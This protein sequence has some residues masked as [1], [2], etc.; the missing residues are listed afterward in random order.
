VG[1]PP[2]SR[3]RDPPATAPTTGPACTPGLPGPP[4]PPASPRPQPFPASSFTVFRQCACGPNGGGFEKTDIP[5]A[6]LTPGWSFVGQGH[7]PQQACPCGSPLAGAARLP[8]IIISAFG[9]PAET[10]AV[11][12][13]ADPFSDGGS[14]HGVDFSAPMFETNFQAPPRGSASPENPP[15]HCHRPAVLRATARSL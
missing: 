9:L 13:T 5:V 8:R 1:G 6:G 10:D 12:G 2:A 14:N 11:P 3:G 4:R 15:D 7:S